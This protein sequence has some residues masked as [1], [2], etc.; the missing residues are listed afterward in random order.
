MH[1]MHA[2]CKNSLLSPPTPSRATEARHVTSHAEEVPDLPF[3][4][5]PS[6]VFRAEVAEGGPL[7]SLSHALHPCIPSP[8]GPSLFPPVPSSRASLAKDAKEVP[9]LPP[10]H[11]SCPHMA[12]VPRV[13]PSPLTVPES[14]FPPSLPLKCY[15]PYGTSS[16]EKT[17]TPLTPMGALSPLSLELAYLPRQRGPFPPSLA[18][19]LRVPYAMHGFHA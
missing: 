6:H 4:L 5:P 8:L 12:S 14:P 1:A 7:P 2:S 11:H 3:T 15:A 16:L 10:L 13:G 19:S 17:T 9:T 18:P